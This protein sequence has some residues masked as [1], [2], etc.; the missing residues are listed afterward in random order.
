M[1]DETFKLNFRDGLEKV[2]GLSDCA[3]RYELS[4]EIIHSTPLLIYS[5]TDYFYYVTL[6]SLYE[7]FFRLEKVF[8]N[9]FARRV[10]QEVFAHYEAMRKV[11]FSQLIAIYSRESK[12]FE[13]NTTKFSDIIS[14]FQNPI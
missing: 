9:L 2:A 3:Q 12:T 1:E 7:S 5:N 10:S 14:K 8:V 11:Y 4:S 13:F 6:L